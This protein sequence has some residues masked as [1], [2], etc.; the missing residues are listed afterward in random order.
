MCIVIQ[1]IS[2]NNNFMAVALQL[3]T[4]PKDLV[5]IYRVVLSP[6]SPAVPSMVAEA[7]IKHTAAAII[8]L[9]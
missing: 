7:T 4:W 5:I 9:M 2:L 3:A 1:D 8:D 6:F